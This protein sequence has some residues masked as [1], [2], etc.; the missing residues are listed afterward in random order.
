MAL[1]QSRSF[2]PPQE[3]GQ[4]SWPMLVIVL[5]TLL[6]IAMTVFL[7]QVLTPHQFF[8][9][10]SFFMSLMFL[11]AFAVVSYLVWVCQIAKKG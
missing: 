8:W 5:G 10:V 6:A 4:K 7:S 3:A 1:I 11:G 9:A 2:T